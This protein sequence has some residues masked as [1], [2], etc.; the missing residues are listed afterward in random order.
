MNMKQALKG[1][2]IVAIV[3]GVARIGMAPSALIWGTNS[4][5]ELI[6]GF[7]ACILMG[8]GIIGVYLY[9]TPQSGIFGLISAMLIAV[10]SSLTAALVWNN[11]L[12]LTPED[13]V[14]IST[15]LSFNSILML[16]GQIVF[17]ISAVR[18]RVY[19]L[20]SLILF[21]VYPVIYFIPTAISNLG[22]VAW[23]LC[24]IVF[25][26]YILQERAR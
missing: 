7:V 1:L 4:M 20:W 23:G 5:P 21:I 16:I 14:Y 24:Y 3:G 8:I 18:A 15:L 10:G 9:Q 12:G 17:S 11:M 22:S 13:H 2:A 19:P 6:C 26:L 25:G